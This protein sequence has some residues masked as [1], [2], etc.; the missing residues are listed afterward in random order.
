MNFTCFS[1]LRTFPHEGTNQA[2]GT[3]RLAVYLC[4]RA[5]VFEA[6][7]RQPAVLVPHGVLDKERVPV[8]RSISSD[9]AINQDEVPRGYQ[10]GV[11]G[12]GTLL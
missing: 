8:F 4:R 2:F 3:H 10:V 5:A 7:E 1:K 11:D 6:M 12:F 9:S